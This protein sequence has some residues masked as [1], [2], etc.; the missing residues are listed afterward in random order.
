MKEF[1]GTYGSLVMLGVQLLLAWFVWS[2]RQEFLSRKD[3]EKNRKEMAGESAKSLEKLGSELKLPSAKTIADVEALK[4]EVAKLPDRKEIQ[5]FTKMV[6]ELNSAL[7]ELK[8]R[9][10]GINRAVDLMNQHHINESGRKGH[11]G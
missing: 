11:E 3:C 5:E 10:N 1:F 8:G 4:L 9:I 6:V 7:G 2:M